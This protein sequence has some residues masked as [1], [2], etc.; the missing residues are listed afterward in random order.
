LPITPD[1]IDLAHNPDFSIATIAEQAH[2]QAEK[3]GEE[4]E[5]KLH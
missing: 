3:R 4:V 5:I 1:I 2:R